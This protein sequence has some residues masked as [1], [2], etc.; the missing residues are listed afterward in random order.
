MSQRSPYIKVVSMTLFAAVLT[1]CVTILFGWFFEIIELVQIIPGSAPLQPNSALCFTLLSTYLLAYRFQKLYWLPGIVLLLSSLTLLEYCLGQ[2]LGIDNLLVHPFFTVQSTYPGRMSLNTSISFLLFSVGILRSCLS[3]GKSARTLTC[4]LILSCSAISISAV[5]GYALGLETSYGWSDY[6]RMALPTALCF[7][8]L[9]TAAVLDLAANSKVSF[10]AKTLLPVIVCAGSG[11]FLTIIIWISAIESESRLVQARIEFDAQSRLKLIQSTL[12]SEID[13][14]KGLN[15]FFISS[16][17]VTRDEFR[18]YTLPFLDEYGGL[19][20]IDWSPRITA[21]ERQDFER[22]FEKIGF[23]N[24]SLRQLDENRKLADRQA[25][26]VYYPVLYSEPQEKNSLAVGFDHYSDPLRKRAMDRA[27]IERRPII[28][29]PFKLFRITQQTEDPS[30][31]LVVLPVFSQR[32]REPQGFIVGV[33]RLSKV[34]D[35]AFKNLPLI[36]LNIDVKDINEKHPIQNQHMLYVGAPTTNT[37]LAKTSL[38]STFSSQQSLTIAGRT[39]E[40]TFSASEYYL[41]LTRTWNAPLVLLFGIALTAFISSYVFII[42][43]QNVTVRKLVH[44]QTSEIKALNRTLENKVEERTR[45]LNETKRFAESVTTNSLSLIYVYEISTNTNVYVNHFVED[46][47]GYN[48]GQALENS[49]VPFTHPDD[50]QIML[51]AMDSLAKANDGVIEF[52]IRVKHSSGKW[53]WYWNRAAIFKRNSDGTASQ[54]I[55]TAQDI[56]ERKNTEAALGRSEKELKNAFTHASIGMALVAPNGTWLR[57]NPPLCV[58]VGYSQNELLQKTFQDITHQDDL[59]KDLGYL[60]QVMSN[61]IDTYQME[62][63]YIHKAG[64]IVWVLL[65]VSLVK[66]EFDAPLHFIAQIQDITLRKEVEQALEEKNTL[67]ARATEFKSQFLANMSHEIRTPLTSII[68]YTD[69]LIGDSLNDEEQ[70]V[71]LHTVLRNGQHLLG[72]INDIL[73][74]S[75]I[76]A[77]SWILKLSKR[78]Y[79]ISSQ[80]SEI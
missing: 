68:G 6:T 32:G 1:F 63:R 45:E 9:T 42:Q 12:N 3:P 73:D 11:L 8:V 4:I 14:L 77:G 52:E 30:D 34:F 19:I 27:V 43:H 21:Q 59:A 56:T 75:K 62:K 70:T 7:A 17:D 46:F 44:D 61:E 33:F 35:E 37:S 40:F 51:Q 67:L 22:S 76:E 29:E 66:D 69:S 60:N 50:V 31:F 80:T 48:T 58:I 28:T 79:L 39:W 78:H 55:G 2:P 16:R 38:G 49:L 71:A 36:G 23:K 74:F 24:F 47:L 41:A 53:R 18:S 20:G 54:I 64:H 65:N 72:I 5:V 25:G 15:S 10:Q 13:V 26:D 57:V